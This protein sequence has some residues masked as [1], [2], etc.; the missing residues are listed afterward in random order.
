[1][2]NER[3]IAKAIARVTEHEHK[4]KRERVQ[5]QKNEGARARQSARDKQT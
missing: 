1:M 3:A 5:E 4:Q 2:A